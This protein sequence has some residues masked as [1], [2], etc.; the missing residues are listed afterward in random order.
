MTWLSVQ[1][2]V[3]LAIASGRSAMVQ[4][5]RILKVARGLPNIHRTR[6]DQLKFVI[7]KYEVKTSRTSLPDLISDLQPLFDK[8]LVPMLHSLVKSLSEIHN[9]KIGRIHFDEVNKKRNVDYIFD[10]DEEEGTDDAKRFRTDTGFEYFD[11]EEEIEHGYPYSAE[12]DLVEDM[13]GNYLAGWLD[14]I[15]NLAPLFDDTNQPGP[16]GRPTEEVRE[17]P[18]NKRTRM[19]DNSIKRPKPVPRK[20]PVKIKKEESDPDMR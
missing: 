4:I 8:S 7:A 18:P 11:D 10:D 17:R 5:L 19:E 3:S 12:N 14:N 9:A 13:S 2:Q 16:S 1:L 20:V 15:K 6:A